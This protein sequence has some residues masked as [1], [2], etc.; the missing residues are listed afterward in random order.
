MSTTFNDDEA[1]E[2]FLILDTLARSLNGHDENVNHFRK[3]L[4]PIYR[5]WHKATPFK[6]HPA[7][8]AGECGC[9]NGPRQGERE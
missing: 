5:D 6:V 9:E 7:F 4:L 1:Y 2:L 3:R 8:A